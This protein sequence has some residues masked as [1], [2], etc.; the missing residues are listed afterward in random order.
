M[1]LE[2][3]IL[4]VAVELFAHGEREFHGY[5]LAARMAEAS[6][7]QKVTAYGTLYRALGRLKKQGL[8]ERRWEDPDRAEAEGRPRRRLYTVTG[9]GE[10]ALTQARQAARA[11]E[12]GAGRRLKDGL[13]ST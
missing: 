7:A 3:A 11:A 4:E 9:A 12:K 10:I 2:V 13:A 1:K 6:S 8:L 5:A